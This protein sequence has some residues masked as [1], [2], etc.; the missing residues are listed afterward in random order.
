LGLV[1]LLAL[2][3][4][5][6]SCGK[7]SAD[8]SGG[9]KAPGENAG[10][11]SKNI[12]EY[13]NTLTDNT[14]EEDPEYADINFTNQS[15][16]YS[17]IIGDAP[18]NDVTKTGDEKSVSV[19]LCL[20]K[21]EKGKI[22]ANGTIDL[23]E[24]TSLTPY[25]LQMKFEHFN[26]TVTGE[27]VT[28]TGMENLS[29]KDN[30]GT[31][32]NPLYDL[33]LTISPIGNHYVCSATFKM[34]SLNRTGRFE[35]SIYKTS[36]TTDA[37]SF[38]SNTWG[39]QGPGIPVKFPQKSYKAQRVIKG[40]TDVAL[41]S[42]QL[43]D[44]GKEADVNGILHIPSNLSI[45]GD[46]IDIA[47]DN[48]KAY[49][50]EPV[51]DTGGTDDETNIT[52]H[53]FKF[54][55]CGILTVT[56]LTDKTPV[57]AN[58]SLTV[59]VSAQNVLVYKPNPDYTGYN[60]LNPVTPEIVTGK[61]TQ[62]TAAVSLVI[63][64][65]DKNSTVIDGVD[66]NTTSKTEIR[67]EIKRTDVDT[68][69]KPLNAVLEIPTMAG[70]T[71][72]LEGGKEYSLTHGLSLN[73]YPTEETFNATGA[74]LGFDMSFSSGSG[75]ITT[76]FD[77]YIPDNVTPLGSPALK[78]EL[79]GSPATET[80]KYDE[81]GKLISKSYS[82]K[83]VSIEKIFA[84][85]FKTKTT[86]LLTLT[87]KKIN[88]LEYSCDV[89]FKSKDFVTD[90]AFSAGVV[91]LDAGN[92]QDD[93]AIVPGHFGL[94]DDSSHIVEVTPEGAGT[95]VHTIPDN[96]LDI[97]M[98]LGRRVESGDVSTIAGGT[99]IIQGLDFIQSSIVYKDAVITTDA[100]GK[101]LT[102]KG[103]WSYLNAPVTSDDSSNDLTIHFIENTTG[104][105]SFDVT[106]VVPGENGGPPRTVAFSLSAVKKFGAID[107]LA[108]LLSES[109]S[110]TGD[111]E[112]SVEK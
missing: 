49:I 18:G 21:D 17:P 61:R 66:R 102:I 83:D 70:G 14:V 99:V 52:D 81:D 101:D 94:S 23:D 10:E 29:T 97:T 43:S 27:K 50:L 76:D 86:G 109:L 71:F 59:T 5:L 8:K 2:V 64:G 36:E 77:I 112:N 54:N 88:S 1:F 41:L 24:S 51:A 75:A 57:E 22:Y 58:Y 78:I 100:N 37:A 85:Y 111:S 20:V 106:L 34:E 105:R 98:K 38:V 103:K 13:W 93:F 68:S 39:K 32:I 53:F 47:I 11:S 63:D 30:A 25:P 104:G 3:F 4:S 107:L 108:P 26:V 6:T 9:S 40:E 33:T 87:F 7:S 55:Q 16:T 44:T 28:I 48:A 91:N 67:T 92:P 35:M 96:K 15:V 42:F 82:M 80:L 56:S 74:S 90:F 45:N 31:V 60:P 110:D 12:V 46:V 89:I 72:V 69:E 65:I 62:Y 79:Q 73:N 84:P 19:K 95:T